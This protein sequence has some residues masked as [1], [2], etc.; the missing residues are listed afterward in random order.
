MM[1]LNVRHAW[2]CND[3]FSTVIIFSGDMG[4]ESQSRLH[5]NIRSWSYKWQ[6]SAE[7]VESVDW[8]HP[9]QFQW[10]IE[11]DK[12]HQECFYRK[13]SVTYNIIIDDWNIGAVFVR[14]CWYVNISEHKLIKYIHFESKINYDKAQWRE[15]QH[16]CRW[17]KACNM[18][19]RKSGQASFHRRN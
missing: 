3:I 6:G 13:I 11:A 4:L 19:G 16:Y 7:W 8:R 10:Q 2:N 17:L 15:H 14:V 9:K 5:N 18:T 1:K 12:Y